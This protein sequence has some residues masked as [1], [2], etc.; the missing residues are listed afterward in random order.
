MTELVYSTE[1][2]I[3]L[4]IRTC[5]LQNLSGFKSTDLKIQNMSITN[6]EYYT[7]VPKKAGG[8]VY[9]TEYNNI[10]IKKTETQA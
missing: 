9:S 2:V 1:F 3:I 4:Y 6:T 7:W 8:G 5:R 10:I